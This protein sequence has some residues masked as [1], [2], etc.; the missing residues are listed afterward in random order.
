VCSATQV[1]CG[2]FWDWKGGAQPHKN[3]SRSQL[4]CLPGTKPWPSTW[5]L[6]FVFNFGPRS[7]LLVLLPR[8]YWRVLLKKLTTRE[9]P[10]QAKQ[11]T[12]TS[13]AL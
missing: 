4:A 11:S 6:P 9:T 8:L 1:F 13:S 10:N 5:A 3:R 7:S 2:F 12:Q